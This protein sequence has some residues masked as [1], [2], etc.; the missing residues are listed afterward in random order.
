MRSTGW[1][2]LVGALAIVATACSGSDSSDDAQPA[3]VDRQSI[4][5]INA[6]RLVFAVSEL[7]DQVDDEAILAVADIHRENG[8]NMFANDCD[9]EVID[10]VDAALCD[11]LSR[12]PAADTTKQEVLDATASI[13]C[14]DSP[15][16]SVPAGSAPT[17]A[18][19]PTATVRPDSTTT[20]PA[21]PPIVGQDTV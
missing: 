20:M 10:Q 17:S 4:C 5:Q 15:A 19:A 11:Y 3:P 13:Y 8:D 2:L 21:D 18:T 6:E 9:V 7:P 16:T 12:T 1:L 14:E